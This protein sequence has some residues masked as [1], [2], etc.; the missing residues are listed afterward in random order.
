MRR[1]PARLVAAVTTASLL[2]GPEELVFWSSLSSVSLATMRSACSEFPFHLNQLAKQLVHG[3]V[4]RVFGL[5]ASEH[6]ALL[7]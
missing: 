2:T 1:I 6:G 3:G 5:V 4:Q 7:T